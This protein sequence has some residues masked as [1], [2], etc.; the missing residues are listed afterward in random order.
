MQEHRIRKRDSRNRCS[1]N[2]GNFA[3]GISDLPK[4]K[5]PPTDFRNYRPTVVRRRPCDVTWRPEARY[6]CRFTYGLVQINHVSTSRGH[7]STTQ[8][9]RTIA[10]VGRGYGLKGSDWRIVG[11]LGR[12][13]EYPKSEEPLSD[14]HST[15]VSRTSAERRV[16]ELTAD[17]NKKV[18]GFRVIRTRE[19]RPR[20]ARYAQLPRL[21]SV[22][23]AAA[24]QC[25][26]NFWRE[27][28]VLAVRGLRS[29][30]VLCYVRTTVVDSC[31][32]RGPNLD[33]A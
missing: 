10:A 8:M 26:R 33:P 5:E 15:L 16:A 3:S 17:K 7:C 32:D 11:R 6:A 21:T 27:K 25:V 18:N 30:C 2:R 28:T 13:T 31:Y 22:I 14:G 1:K 19:Q 20:S 12:T 9:R 29:D 23:A 4:G 24:A